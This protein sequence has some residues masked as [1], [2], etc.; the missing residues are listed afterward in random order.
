MISVFHP[1]M[2]ILPGNITDITTEDEISLVKV[3][4]AGNTF[5]AIVIDT[6]ERSAYLRK[7]VPVRLLF[8]E[9][10]V[11]IAALAAGM[12]GIVD[13]IHAEISVLL[14]THLGKI[15]LY[16][17]HHMTKLIQALILL[18]DLRAP[19]KK[20]VN[21]FKTF[22]DTDLAAILRQFVLYGDYK[23][24][25]SQTKIAGVKKDM[26]LNDPAVQKLAKALEDFFFR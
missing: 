18:K 13:K 9:T 10:E 12:E 5:T 2:N 26:D 17:E 3:D 20:I 1:I 15:D 22:S 4:A 23:T 11:M 8:K 21:L 24:N 6:P 7:G 25:T 19:G 14:R 16:N